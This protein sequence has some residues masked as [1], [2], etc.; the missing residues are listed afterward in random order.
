MPKPKWA[1]PH[2]PKQVAKLVK[3]AKEILGG[4]AEISESDARKLAPLTRYW[5]RQFA[6]DNW[7]ILL[8]GGFL[9]FCLGL[10]I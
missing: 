10:M 3:E 8:F 2:A 5:K 6:Y 1:K 9:G 4:K 7:F